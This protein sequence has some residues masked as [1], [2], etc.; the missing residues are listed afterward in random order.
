[1]QKEMTSR[2]FSLQASGVFKSLRC[3]YPRWHVLPAWSW[4]LDPD[5]KRRRCACFDVITSPIARTAFHI[6]VLHFG[7]EKN[8]RGTST[9][10]MDLWMISVVPGQEATET[11]SKSHDDHMAINMVY[12]IISFKRY[13]YHIWYNI[14]IYMYIYMYRYIYI[15]KYMQYQHLNSINLTTIHTKTQQS[16]SGAV[17][18]VCAICASVKQVHHES[19]FQKW[20]HEHGP[21]MACDT[22]PETN[23]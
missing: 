6:Y 16:Q 13:T 1:M 8:M 2:R 5:A 12:G 10:Y 19:S 7:Q 22:L 9:C 21:K 14:Y 11:S 20:R 23:S 17:F 4:S 18:V 3:W 15:H